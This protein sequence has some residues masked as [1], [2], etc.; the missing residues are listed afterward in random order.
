MN[1]PF[2]SLNLFMFCLLPG[3][4]LSSTTP[5]ST[6]MT[7]TMT[8]IP[9]QSPSSST[10]N[11]NKVVYLPVNS[12]HSSSTPNNAHAFVYANNQPPIRDRGV[13]TAGGPK[14]IVLSQTHQSH[15]TSFN[16][17]NNTNNGIVNMPP[18]A[19]K[20]E[21]AFTTVR[22]QGNTQNSLRQ[23]SPSDSKSSFSNIAVKQ[24]H[25]SD[26]A[27]DNSRV[28]GDVL[29]RDG[30]LGPLPPPASVMMDLNGSDNMKRKQLY[31][32]NISLSPF[33]VDEP[34]SPAL[35]KKRGRPPTCKFS[36]IRYGSMSLHCH[37]N[38]ADFVADRL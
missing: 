22:I 7:M 6:T 35:K 15:N 1:D 21:G 3:L 38:V 29:G 14:T 36:F 34:S 30:N 25:N 20:R 16:S 26:Y 9:V 17:N 28:V 32:E 12:L 8:Y 24:E 23:Q 18:N 31:L 5:A 11:S 37:A 10:S 27:N 2:C 13:L 4:G 19:V 33:C